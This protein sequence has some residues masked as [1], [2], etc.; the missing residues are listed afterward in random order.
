MHRAH[1]GSGSPWRALR[2]LGDRPAL[3][4]LFAID[5]VYWMAFAVYQTTFAL[6]GARR[7]GFD[8]AHTGY[9]FSAFGLLG[10]IVQGG[11]VGPVVRRLGAKRTLMIGLVFAALG[12]GR[13]RAD[14]LGA[15]VRRCCW[16][17]RRSASACAM[18][19]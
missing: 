14:P 9:L 17:R 1:A 8:A 13:Q 2:E 5:F 6:F 11:L 19:R 12:L 15:A 18:R 4:R 3:R 10:V 16:C 7:F